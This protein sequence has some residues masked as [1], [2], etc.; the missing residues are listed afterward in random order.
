MQKPSSDQ[1]FRSLE[2]LRVLSGPPRG[3]REGSLLLPKTSA[4]ATFSMWLPPQK[5][6]DQSLIIIQTCNR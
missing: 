4:L 3:W 5:I 1:G 6:V 2:E